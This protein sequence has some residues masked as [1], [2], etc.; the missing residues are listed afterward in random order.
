MIE[1]R[2]R[3]PARGV[4]KRAIG[5]EPGRNV[6][7]VRGSREIRLVARITGS[8]RVCVIVVRVALGASQRGMSSG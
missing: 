3:P 6:I 4:A 1:S 5:R 7:R 8:R 2:R